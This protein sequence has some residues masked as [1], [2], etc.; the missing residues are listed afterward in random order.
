MKVHRFFWNFGYLYSLTDSGITSDSDVGNIKEAHQGGDRAQLCHS[1]SFPSLHWRT[2]QMFEVEIGA[3]E[4][5][6]TATASVL[7]SITNPFGV[8]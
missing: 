1:T 4:I 6:C 5:R 8:P 2:D 3:F 7:S